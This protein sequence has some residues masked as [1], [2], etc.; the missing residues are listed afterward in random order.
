MSVKDADPCPQQTGKLF[1][2]S[3]AS[4]SMFRNELEASM[5]IGLLTTGWQYG[6]VHAVCAEGR[7]LTAASLRQPPP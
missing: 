7:S 4:P 6:L 5:Y 1:S 3:L 2:I